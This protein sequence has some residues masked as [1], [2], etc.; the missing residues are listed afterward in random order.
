MTPVLRV[1]VGEPLVT[2]GEALV[3]PVTA[4]LEG[5]T[6]WAREAERLGGAA[7]GDR[8]A[9]MGTL[10]PGAVLVTPAGDLPFDLLLHLVLLAPG[11]PLGPDL[12]LRGT[13]NALNQAGEWELATLVFPL[14]GVGPG[15]LD[16]ETAVE[17]L[18]DALAGVE[19]RTTLH[20][21]LP[22]EA[23]ARLVAG[24]LEGALPDLSVLRG[25]VSGE[26][27]PGE[28]VQGGSL[29]PG[30]VLPGPIPPG[31]EAEP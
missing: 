19:L 5:I 6:P 3:R 20:L 12:L 11:E 24:V 28:S 29:P 27:M 8:L 4:A 15:Q 25:S 22:D 14:L 17:V 26:P 9:G 23:Q 31:W 16:L 7:L 1:L 18:A 10:P 2:P 21:P 13:R 30:S